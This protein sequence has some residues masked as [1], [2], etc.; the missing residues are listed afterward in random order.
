MRPQDPLLRWRRIQGEPVRLDYPH[1]PPPARHHLI[2]PPLQEHLTLPAPHTPPP[3]H[4]TI[5]G[6]SD[7]PSPAHPHTTH[8]TRMRAPPHAAHPSQPERA[9][10]YRTA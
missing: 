3:T 9:I 2:H 1:P 4:P 7:I 10:A 8:S 5:A 6:T